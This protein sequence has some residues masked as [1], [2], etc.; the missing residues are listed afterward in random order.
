M[1][2]RIPAPEMNIPA[3]L[4]AEA[5]SQTFTLTWDA[6]VNVTGY[7]VRIALGDV[8]ETVATTA[9]SLTVTTFGGEKLQN[10]TTYTVQVQSLNGQWRSGYG[11]AVTVTPKADKLPA[12]PDA[13][14]LTGRFQRID[15]S[16]KAMKDTDS[17]NLYYRKAGE[18]TLPEG[19]GPVPEQ[20]HHPESGKTTP[21]MR[22][23]SPASTNWAKA[24][25]R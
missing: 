12:A 22:C 2:S 5:G 23:T 16:W 10:N 13:L 8:T 14:T 21:G 3:N 9:N 1:E 17:Y 4:R 6:Q 7:E 18:E 24:R 25:P 11:E 20:L 15:A 19:G